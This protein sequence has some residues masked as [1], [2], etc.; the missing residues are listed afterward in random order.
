MPQKVYLDDNGNLIPAAA[1][2]RRAAAQRPATKVYLDEQGN[3][4]Q[5]GA[6]PD[7]PQG[8]ATIGEMATAQPT[9]SERAMSRVMRPLGADRPQPT[10]DAT[11]AAL[12]TAAAHPVETGAIAGGAAMSLATGGL[13]L[14]VAAGLVGLAGAGGAGYGLAGRQVATGR[15]EPVDQSLRTMGEQ[16]IAAAA[17]EGGGRALAAGATRSASWLMNRAV[18]VSD[19]LAREFPE[20]SQS[21]I[22]NAIT[23][24]KHGYGR[25]RGM[26][27]AAKNTA[28][29]ALKKAEQAGATVPIQVTEEIGD[30]LRTAIIER[31]IKAG[32]AKATP[33]Q[34]L[35][36]AT[37]RLD[38][39]T[40][41]LLGNIDQAMASGNPFALAPTIA[42]AL[43]TQL[44]R[45]SRAFYASMK[46]PSGMPAIDTAKT[47]K[48]EFAARLN[49]TLDGLAA[50]Y[51]AANNTAR[52][53]I[54]AT[55]GVGRAIRPGANL[56]QAMV[57]PGVGMMIGGMGG[58]G[59]EG[60]SR[61]TAIGAVT[62]A[63]MLSP[64]GMSRTAI[65]LSQPAVKTF[66]QQLP[67]PVLAAV[68]AALDSPESPQV[69]PTGSGQ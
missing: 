62:G 1:L 28:N 11:R 4:I 6:Q 60:S 61:G 41:S 17:G 69:E 46:G 35:T 39:A 23:V 12:R 16:G 18:N 22:D 31:A 58:Y 20:L 21:L 27:L 51:K 68:M 10:V 5:P 29:A 53:M 26:L 15:P 64:A 42:D 37:A 55:R 33:G 8:L 7:R 13:A 47:V 50:G 59:S 52:E 30:S 14:P 45:E 3:P 49:E 66:L 65:A 44:Q 43:K 24:S 38:P 63:A 25:A 34:P 19:K 67:K 40:Q 2:A 48:A 32:T 36:V 9:R 57:R 54:G 56:Y